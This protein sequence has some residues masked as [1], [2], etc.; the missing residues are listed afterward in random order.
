MTSANAHLYLD[1]FS[2][3]DVAVGDRRVLFHLPTSSL[4][5]LDRVGGEVLDFVKAHHAFSEADV[6]DWILAKEA[7]SEA[8]TPAQV[9][10]VLHDFQSIDI[11]RTSPDQD[12]E[13]RVKVREF[14]L[15][16]LVISVSTG[17]NL[18]CSYCY[19]EDLD[20]PSKSR[21]MDFDTASQGIELLLREGASRDQLNV[22]FLGG[23][24]LTNLPLIKQVVDYAERRCA[25]EGK[26]V[27]FTMT[28]NATL[29]TEDIV[30]YLDQHR[31]G[32][33]ISMDGP[34]ALHDR[35][36]ITIGGKGTYATVAAKAKML[37]GRYRSRP[38]GAR[39]TLSAGST[40][41]VGI[42]RHLKN[43]IGFFEVGFAPV[44]TSED[45]ALNLSPEE[46]RTV[47]EGLKTL[48]REYLEAAL[49]NHNLGFS[50]MHQLMSDLYEGRKK[51]L[52]CGAG[53]GLLALDSKGDLNLCHRFTGSS[54]PTFGNVVDGIAKD[55]LGEFLEAAAD[56][57]GKPCA[58]CRIRKLCAG[59]CYH[60]SYAR[61]TD[62][63]SP[64]YLYCDFMREWVDFGMTVYVEL[65][66]KNSPF[67]MQHID[68]RRTKQ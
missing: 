33:S 9:A 26:R 3:H 52:P 59:G 22:V 62:P 41:V 32:I 43:D 6:R 37:I 10:E 45:D 56:L 27:D 44:T 65:L 68:S 4:F 55:S 42:Y 2:F 34:Q 24:P 29:L 31:F 60:E 23:E 14:P 40:D 47:F 13:P 38:V 15:S 12:P 17:C 57:T 20:K 66:D 54:L 1:S 48:G 18:S 64:T 61:Y 28:T 25:E 21:K 30:G 63:L 39:V 19:K 51:S 35:R 58:T 67:L 8:L 53:V 7:R 50:N 46:L 5:E 36:R 49:Q 16:S 11:L